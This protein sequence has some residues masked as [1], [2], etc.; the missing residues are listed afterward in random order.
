MQISVALNQAKFELFRWREQAGLPWKI[1][2]AALMAGVVGLLAQVR[3]PL[4]FTPVPLTGQTF[5]V[6]MAGVLLGRKWGGASLGVYAVLGIIGVPW[7]NGAT[8]GMTATA[9]YLVG[10]ILASLFLGYFIDKMPDKSNF[11]RMFGLMLFASVVLIYVPGLL[12]LGIWLNL[13]KGPPAGLLTVISFGAAPFIAGDILKTG[14]AAV[15]AVKILPRKS[16][17]E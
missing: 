14:I 9:G 17:A 3:V 16:L 10:F 15:A 4:P 12:W 5:G 13:V 11:N 8:S 2:M 6:L 1:T 7:F